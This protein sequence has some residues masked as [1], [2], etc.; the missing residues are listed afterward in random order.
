MPILSNEEG[1]SLRA[2]VYGNAM[3]WKTGWI[4]RTTSFG[5]RRRERQKTYVLRTMRLA[6]TNRMAGCSGCSGPESTA[7]SPRCHQAGYGV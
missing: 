7:R 1:L 4:R 2:I 5:H 6:T 3:N